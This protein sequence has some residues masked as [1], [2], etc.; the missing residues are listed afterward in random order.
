MTDKS[1]APT[2]RSRGIA[3]LATSINLSQTAIRKT[4]SMDNQP[5]EQAELPTLLV[6]ELTAEDIEAMRILQDEMNNMEA[7]LTPSH[8]DGD[9][10]EEH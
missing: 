5:I 2:Y 9:V 3:A 10:I 6:S 4:L 8:H 1:I 7:P